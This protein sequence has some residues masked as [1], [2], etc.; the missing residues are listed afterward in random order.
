MPV[1]LRDTRPFGPSNQSASL[2]IYFKR[3]TF[4]PFVVCALV[5]FLYFNSSLRPGR[6]MLVLLRDTRPFGPSSQSASLA[7]YFKRLTFKPFI[8]CALVF[9]LCFNLPSSSLR[10]VHCPARS[11]NLDDSA[12]L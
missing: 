6:T 8:V 3:L 9:F 7:I 4:T 11:L 10:G 2:A 1:L 12:W 5:F